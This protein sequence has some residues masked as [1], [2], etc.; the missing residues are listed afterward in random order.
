MLDPERRFSCIRFVASRLKIVSLNTWKNEGE[1]EKRLQLMGDGLESLGPDIVLLQECFKCG[2]TGE[3]TAARL[4]ERLQMKSVLVEARTKERLHRGKR[5]A[6]SSGNAVLHRGQ[7]LARERLELPTSEVGGERVLLKTKVA[8]EGLSLVIGCSHFS[9]V[10]GEV[11]LRK[12]QIETCLKVLLS[13]DDSDAVFLGGD[14]NCEPSGPELSAIDASLLGRFENALRA[15]A[16]GDGT[17]PL[18]PS[19]H[20]NQR[21]I[22]QIWASDWKNAWSLKAAGVAMTEALGQEGIYPS[23][24]AA[25]WAEFG[26]V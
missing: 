13:E 12:E 8:W 7:M 15:V 6:C 18:P 23:D 3:N 17:N 20:R 21:Q 16:C 10:R 24:H 4:A 11:S 26:E 22:D 2:E 5:R 1:Y 19:S 14:F 25:V 9:H